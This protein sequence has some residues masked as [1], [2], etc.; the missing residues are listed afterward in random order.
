M[1]TAFTACAR[2]ALYGSLG[3]SIFAA[4]LR[5]DAI[6]VCSV[7]GGHAHVAVDFLRATCEMCL[8][9]APQT[10]DLPIFED[11]ITY[12]KPES[13]P[14]SLGSPLR[15]AFTLRLFDDMAFVRCPLWLVMICEVGLLAV[16]RMIRRRLRP[17]IAGSCESC[18]Y[19]LDGNVSGTCPECGCKI[20]QAP[21]E[22]GRV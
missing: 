1:I 15:G 3:A 22:L 16:L 19:C 4:C 8:R 11:G 14:W 9:T 18:G 21:R 10:D 5:G 2:I 20:L 6:L 13:Q 17:P 7:L 12:L